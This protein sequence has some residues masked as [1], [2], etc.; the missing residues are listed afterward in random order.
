MTKAANQRGSHLEEAV[1][2]LIH[3]QA[4]FVSQLAEASRQNEKQFSEIRKLFGTIEAML[5]RHERILAD[6]PEAIRQKIGF[7]ES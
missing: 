1:A 2:L 4:S 3:T 6:L 5:L 7:Q